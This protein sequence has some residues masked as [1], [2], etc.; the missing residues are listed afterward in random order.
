MFSSLIPPLRRAP[1]AA[2][3]MRANSQ[4]KRQP[5]VDRLEDYVLLAPLV[6]TVRNI[7]DGGIGSLR[8]A[9]NAANTNGVPALINFDISGQGPQIIHVGA[10][11]PSMSVQVTIDGWSQG[12]S[13]YKGPPL[14]VIDGSVA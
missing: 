4:R 12:G 9:M 13:M 7:Q 5:E 14:I 2:G 1:R 11:L 10:A 8:S 3:W 6:Y